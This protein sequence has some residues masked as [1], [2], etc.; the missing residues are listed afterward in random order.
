MTNKEMLINF[1]EKRLEYANTDMGN[2]KHIWRHQAYGAVDLYCTLFPEEVEKIEKLW[3][4]KYYHLF[5]W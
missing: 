4:E 1:I 5:G 3:N 2:N